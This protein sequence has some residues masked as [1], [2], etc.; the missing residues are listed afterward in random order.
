MVDSKV[1]KTHLGVSCLVVGCTARKTKLAPASLRA[2]S[3]PSG[4]QPEVG[5]R[6]LDALRSRDA[7]IS[8]ARAVDL[9]DGLSF[10]RA[11]RLADE[12][13]VD[14]AIVSAG[15]G[16][17]RGTGL[18][19]SYDLTLASTS[20]DS[21]ARAVTTRFDAAAWWATVSQGPFAQRVEGVAE[22]PGRILVAITRPYAKLVGEAFAQLPLHTRT[23]LRFLG[24]GLKPILPPSLQ[25]YILSYGRR[26]DVLA[27]GTRLDAPIRAA[28]HFGRLMADVPLETP[29]ADQALVEAALAGVPEPNP[30]VRRRVEDDTLRDIIRSIRQVRPN[31]RDALTELRTLHGVACER[32]RFQRLFTEVAP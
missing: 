9:Y 2:S 19:P 30:P 29:E 10:R 14:L 26:L 6:W 24:E 32:N 7:S 1:G 21:I 12:L 15:L 4:F 22:R 16:L 27:R 11:R 8:R 5:A 3:L 25:P 17:V 28:E 20:P 23:R 31:A 18:I 13:E